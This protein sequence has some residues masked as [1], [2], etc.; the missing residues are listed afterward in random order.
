MDASRGSDKLK[1]MD[2]IKRILLWDY[3][4]A[5]WQYDVIVA[6]ILAF[7]FVA[8]AYV[9]FGDRPRPANIAMVHGGYWIESQQLSGVPEG[10]LNKEAATLINAKYKNHAVISTVEPI[11]DESEKELKGYLAFPK[12]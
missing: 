9:S 5:S 7:V 1:A 8:P 3:P 2:V 6:L 11:Y 10:L 12:P 4:R